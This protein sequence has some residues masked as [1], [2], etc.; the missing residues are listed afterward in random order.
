MRKWIDRLGMALLVCG[1]MGLRAQN[2]TIDPPRVWATTVGGV[3]FDFITDAVT[4]GQGGLYVTGYT[5]SPNFP[6]TLVGSPGVG[7]DAFVA[8]VDSLGALVWSTRYGGS[9]TDYGNAIARDAAGNLV[10]AGKL[11]GHGAFVTDSTYKGSGDDILVLKLSGAGAFMGAVR[12]GG[13]A[14]DEAVGIATD[15]QNQI[16]VVGNASSSDIATTSATFNGTSGD[17][18]VLRLRSNLARHLAFRY[19][20]NSFDKANDVVID[21]NGNFYVVGETG[22]ANFQQTISTYQGSGGAKAFAIRFDSLGNRVWA[23]RYGGSGVERAYAAELPVNGGLLIGGYTTSGDFPQTISGLGGSGLDAFLIHLN[24]DGTRDYARRLGGSLDDLALDIATDAHGNVFMAGETQSS[25]FP[26]TNSRFQGQ[27]RDQFVAKFSPAG[28]YEWS[29]PFGGNQN[30]FSGGTLTSAA[31]S[32]Y[33]AGHTQSTNYPQ[34]LTGTGGSTARGSILRLRDCLGQSADF[35]FQHVCEYDTVVFQNLS[36]QGT[37]DT[38]AY[39]WWFGDGDSSDVV[40]PVHHYAQPGVYACTLRVTSPCGVD[41]VVTKSV[42]VYPMPRV[43]WGH[44]TACATRATA[45][46]DST[47]LDTAVGSFENG[48]LWSFGTG[49]TSFS[50]NPSYVFPAPGT[51]N[52]TFRVYTNHGCVDSLT[53]QVTA[54]HRPYA[55]FAVADVCLRDSAMFADSTLLG[56][57]NLVQWA[58]DFGDGGSSSTQHPHY[59]YANAD[60]FTVQL[61]TTTDMGC[62]DTVQHDIKVLPLPVVD[63]GATA[64]CW[65]A[66]VDFTES[67]TI[68]GDSI[69]G[70]VWQFGDSLTDTLP[71]SSHAYAASGTYPVVLWAYTASGCADSLLQQV[72]VHDKPDA[73]FTAQDLCWPEVILFDDNSTLQDDSLVSWQWAFGDGGMDSIADPSHGYALADSYQVSLVVESGFGCRDT[74]EKTV[75]SLPKPVADFNAPD[76]C[77]PL[78]ANFTSTSTVT[79]DMITSWDWDFGDGGSSGLPVTLHFYGSN[80]GYLVTLVVETASGCKDTLQDSVYRH[81]QPNSDFNAVPACDG[82]TV[83]FMDA[84]SVSSGSITQYNYLLGD[85]NSATVADTGHVYPGAG[86]YIVTHQVTTD[87]GCTDFSIQTIE[88]FELPD[89]QPM[90]MGYPDICIGDTAVLVTAQPFVSY[91]WETGDTTSWIA[92]ASR[93]D[94]VTLSVIDSNGCAGADSVEVRFHAVPRPNAVILPGPDVQSCSA[95]SLFLEAGGSYASYLWS[96]GEAVD[97]RFVSSSGALWVLVN[98]GFGCA[99]TSDIVTVTIHQSPNAP[100]IS[101]NGNVLTSSFSSGF[102]WYFNGM[103]IPNATTQSWTPTSTGSYHV[104]VTDENGCTAASNVVTTVVGVAHDFVEDFAVYPNPIA[105]DVHVAGLLQRGGEM[106]VRIVNATG[107]VVIEEQHSVS[108][109]AFEL[110]LPTGALPAGYY[111]LDVQLGG[112]RMLRSLVRQ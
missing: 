84:S 19:G 110:E 60:T 61:I 52:V 42:N 11:G 27:G 5:N 77:E 32:V 71:N 34:T 81:P 28:A 23:Q 4:D 58:W 12:Y 100:I 35:S 57:D 96:D 21:A 97:R 111:L 67:T 72:K 69:V 107:Q 56:G 80:G 13:S 14:N 75:I 16:V 79:G 2:P 7:Y 83:M 51:Y 24:L 46:M 22:S 9:G 106:Q 70:Y 88:V 20:G 102:Q 40:H 6:T 50:Q 18:F 10:V 3:N 33:L 85:G 74:I 104:V 68:T 54:H 17:A 30:D 8:R 112:G 31:A 63:Y 47:V 99:D 89:A 49:A 92:V 59:L 36:G 101:Q 78:P 25:N 94:W 37:S 44:D 65:P 109:G 43:D 105:G 41:S 95:D 53:Q 15:A 93:S 26:S 45:F 64:I 90:V 62:S 48:W 86:T 38:V 91:D 82:D 73:A 103:A 39:R 98:N 66:A 87:Q 1:A 29:F 55:D 108:A 76:V